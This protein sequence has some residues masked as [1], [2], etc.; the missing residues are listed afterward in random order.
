MQALLQQRNGL[1][2]RILTK[3]GVDATQLLTEVER[4]IARQPKVREGSKTVDT[5]I[6][7]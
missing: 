3:A 1:S 7:E 2:R 5:R 6:G 4:Y